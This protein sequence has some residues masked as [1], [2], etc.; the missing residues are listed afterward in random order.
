MLLYSLLFG[1]LWYQIIAHVGISA[2][3]H[4]YFAHRQ[5]KANVIFEWIVLFMST[6]AGARS[7][8]GWIAAHRLHHENSDKPGDP[9]SPTIKGFWTVLFSLWTIKKIPRKI[10]RDLYANPRLAF[11]HNYW[12]V[13]WVTVSVFSFI[14]SPYFFLGFIIVPA[15][16]APIGFGM[17]NALTHRNG[18][19]TN[20]PWINILTA[21]EGYH[22]EHHRNG[23]QLRFHKF[24]LTGFFLEKFLFY[25]R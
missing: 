10:V 25:T 12:A 15:I 1:F 18:I 4:R 6:L 11:F 14:I 24:D 13:I 16:L 19:V 7:P 2:G 9:H 20:I 21:G 3:L 5:F 17:V 8:I 22:A 23:R